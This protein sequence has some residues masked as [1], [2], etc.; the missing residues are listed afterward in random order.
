MKPSFLSL[1]DRGQYAKRRRADP[2]P[3]SDPLPLPEV[4]V[5]NR[6]QS[7]RERFAMA[8]LGFG[9]RFEP[10]FRNSFLAYLR[11]TFGTPPPAAAG[12]EIGIE[13]E[14]DNWCDLKIVDGENIY[15]IE[16]K[17]DAKLKAHQDPS[18]PAF[19]T[20]TGRPAPYGV[21]MLKDRGRVGHPIRYHY[22]V[23]TQDRDLAEKTIT[24]PPKG[25]VAAFREWENLVQSLEPIRSLP[26]LSQ[27][28]IMSLGQIGIQAFE[29]SYNLMNAKTLKIN[30][31]LHSAI[32]ALTI[33][34][35]AIDD[36]K[37]NPSDIEHS[38]PGSDTRSFVG[39]NIGP[40]KLQ[41]T[42]TSEM[43][44]FRNLVEPETPADALAWVGCES[45]ASA[46]EM[47]FI[48]CLYCGTSKHA[49]KVLKALQ[50]P[51]VK[52]KFAAET[53][54]DSQDDKAIYIAILKK[55]VA[56]PV[57][58]W[59]S[60]ILKTLVGVGATELRPIAHKYMNAE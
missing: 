32:N 34:K 50:A 59:F 36:A 26:D 52:R 9:L 39:W 21:E 33:V 40:S 46:A 24:P 57:V 44:S 53:T 3:V 18:Q 14:P 28:L 49:Q 19:Y 25:I 47:R 43:T 16:G 58:N 45:G 30:D 55:D 8:A 41:R 13:I 4:E 60:S 31:D 6:G 54:I 23:L 15:V 22:L 7:Q 27:S 20:G 37:L 10:A 48:V 17:I 51:G 42:E 11:T 2:N 56:D 5:D 35:A 1:F 29:T 12:T 38:M